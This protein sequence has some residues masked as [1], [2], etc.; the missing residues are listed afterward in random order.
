MK[1]RLLIPLVLLAAAPRFAGSA[2]IVY[3]FLNPTFGGNPLNGAVLLNEANA[4]NFFTPPKTSSAAT[5]TAGAGAATPGSAAS[6]QAA[7]NNFKINLESTVLNKLAQTLTN[8]IFPANGGSPQTGSYTVGDY[9][10]DIS[11][12]SGGVN[13][14]ISDIVAGASTS[15]YIPT[16]IPVK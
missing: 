9:V 8:Q 6:V 16:T 12:A 13:V 4:Q 11:T 2:E 15:V 5:G 14:T 10:I 1:H 7:L 3:Q